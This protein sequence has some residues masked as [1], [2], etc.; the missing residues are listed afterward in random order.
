MP[1][2]VSIAEFARSTAASLGIGMTCLGIFG[3]IET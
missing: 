2:S 3:P 1:D